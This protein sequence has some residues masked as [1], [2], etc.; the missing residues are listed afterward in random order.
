MLHGQKVEF[1]HLCMLTCFASCI[2]WFQSHEHVPGSHVVSDC[3]LR[4][5]LLSQS[6]VLSLPA[7]VPGKLKAQCKCSILKVKVS[8]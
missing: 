3:G 7:F 1:Q 2:S 4:H 5:R 8:Q 6:A